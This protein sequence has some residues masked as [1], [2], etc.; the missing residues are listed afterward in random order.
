MAERLTEKGLIYVEVPS[1]L[2]KGYTGHLDFITHINVFSAASLEYLLV[3]CGF[4][5]LELKTSSKANNNGWELVIYAIARLAKNKSTLPRNC[6]AVTMKALRRRWLYP[7][8]IGRLRT[9]WHSRVSKLQKFLSIK[10]L[11]K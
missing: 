3:M 10:V 6:Q 4:E 8:I 5:V 1:E 9:I 11:Q 2:R 7:R